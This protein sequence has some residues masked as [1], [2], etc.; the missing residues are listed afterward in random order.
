MTATP[1]HALQRTRPPRSDCNRGVPRAGSLSEEHQGVQGLPV[2]LHR[3][4]PLHREVFEERC[5]LRFRHVSRMA[6]LVKAHELLIPHHV[7]G[8]RLYRVVALADGLPQLLL[9]LGLLRWWNDANRI[10]G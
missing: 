3:H 8:L 10:A 4:V 2:S 6:Q 5:N 1:N 7:S 9:E